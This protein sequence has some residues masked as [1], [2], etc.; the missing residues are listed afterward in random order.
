M[1]SSNRIWFFVFV[2]E[3]ARAVPS[4]LAAIVGH[5]DGR[6]GTLSVRPFFHCVVQVPSGWPWTGFS[7][8]CR[9]AWCRK[10]GVCVRHPVVMAFDGFV[11]RP[12]KSLVVMKVPLRFCFLPP[13]HSVTAVMSGCIASYAAAPVMSG[14]YFCSCFIMSMLSSVANFLPT[15][16]DRGKGGGSGLPT[17][18]QALF[19]AGVG[20]TDNFAVQ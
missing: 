13:A 19:L 1:K 6:T 7:V 17:F 10:A 9:P 14:L 8:R 4:P 18:C 2:W 11:A 16:L 15:L 20:R 3:G 12:V 5:R